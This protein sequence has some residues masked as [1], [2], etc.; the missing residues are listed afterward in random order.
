VSWFQIAVS[1]RK[2]SDRLREDG[3]VRIRI[4]GTQLPGRDC[5]PGGNF[6]GYSNIHVGL[7]RQNRQ[8]DLLDL[9]PGDAATALWTVECAV[10]GTDVRGPYIQGPSDGR[11]IYLSW[12]SV[13][14]AGR[15]TMFR[16]AKLMLGDVPT[17]VLH[18]AARSGVLVGSPGLTDAQQSGVCACAATAHPL[19]RR[20][21]L[22]QPRSPSG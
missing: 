13:D 18:S 4:V 10:D 12:V 7:Q 6:P 11:F 20:V 15:F 8:D 3:W 2:R 22:F 5:G 21:S 1:R 9:H 19:D 14:D 16:R 17:D